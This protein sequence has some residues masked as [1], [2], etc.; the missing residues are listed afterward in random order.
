MKYLI[1]IDSDG[2]LRH[3]DGTISDRT[4]KAI[5]RLKEQGHIVVICTARPRYHTLQI[6]EQV[7]I[8]DFLISSNG[9]E[10]Y[11]NLT[12]EIIWASYIDTNTCKQIYEICKKENIRLIFVIDDKEYAT[13]FTRNNKQN[14]LN[15]SNFN[16]VIN[17]NVKQI[18][19]IDSCKEKIINLK[20]KLSDDSLL[21]IIDSSDE[22][23][24]EIWFS[25]VSGNSSKG[26]AL[27][28]LASYLKILKKNTIAIG[29]DIN[30]IT[31]LK[32]VGISVAVENAIPEVLSCAKIIT[33]SNDLDG[34]AVFLETLLLN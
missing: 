4:K 29:N 28:K 34:V 23:G 2:T 16:K 10:I 18:M 12:D 21:N 8:D 30:D 9:T 19:I 22:F 32:K 24:E 26:I 25:I 1:L 13:K 17:G 15:D 20:R 31:M 5:Q 11:N 3:S 14:L 7:G 6:S 33:K 27:E